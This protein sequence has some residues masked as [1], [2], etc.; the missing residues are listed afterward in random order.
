[1]AATVDATSKYDYAS[2]I[3]L[4]DVDRLSSRTLAFGS[5]MFVALKLNCALPSG[6][7][8]NLRSH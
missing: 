3:Y 7:A 1:M 5:R 4:T 8:L 6:A 2:I